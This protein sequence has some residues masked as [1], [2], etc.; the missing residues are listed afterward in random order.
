VT[1]TA[2]SSVFGDQST[3]VT[4]EVG[5][6]SDPTPPTGAVS[7][8]TTQRGFGVYIDVSDPE[9]GI[10][11]IWVYGDFTT[12]CVDPAVPGDPGISHRTDNRTTPFNVG[13]ETDFGGTGGGTTFTHRAGFPRLCPAG[14]DQTGPVTLEVWARVQAGN[15]VSIETAHHVETVTP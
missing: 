12:T 2:R 11:E 13:S 6:P 9:S 7:G 5:H 4:I 1:L 14:L 15:G 3:S 8:V 10:E